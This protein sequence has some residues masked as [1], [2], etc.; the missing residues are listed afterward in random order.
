[1]PLT[2]FHDARLGRDLEARVLVDAGGEA[3]IFTIRNGAVI[4]SGWIPVC[5]AGLGVLRALPAGL[6]LGLEA[7][8]RQEL[9]DVKVSLD[10][11]QIDARSATAFDVG[12]TLLW[13]SRASS[14]VE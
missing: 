12:L 14:R 8:V 11:A 10:Q 7:R 5:G 2:G 4:A 13:R 9:R 3:R 1:M 6:T